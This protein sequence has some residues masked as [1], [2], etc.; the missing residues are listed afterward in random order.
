MEHC[1]F[2][3]ERSAQ[4]QKPKNKTRQ[5]SWRYSNNNSSF[6]ELRNNQVTFPL[7]SIQITNYIHSKVSE[8]YFTIWKFMLCHISWIWNR[9]N[10]S[11]SSTKD[12]C[13][14]RRRNCKLFL[15]RVIVTLGNFKSFEMMEKCGIELLKIIGWKRDQTWFSY[16]LC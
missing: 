14:S 10:F 2:P 16:L 6:H 13:I 9:S 5:I 4:I 7:L 11:H 1:D 3:V 15:L 8:V 12:F